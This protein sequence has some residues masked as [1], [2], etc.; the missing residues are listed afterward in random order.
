MKRVAILNHKGGSG[1]T[2]T[3]VNLGAALAEAGKRVLVLDFDPAAG[4]SMWLGAVSDDGRPGLAQA[5]GGSADLSELIRE[6]A[7]PGLEIIPSTLALSKAEKS[8]ASEIGGETVLKRK[9]SGLPSGR[10]D[11]LLVDCPPTLGLLTL[12]ALSAASHVLIPVEAHVMALS[13]VVSL[14]ETISI[15][16]ER[17]NPGLSV[18]GVLACR[19]DGRTLHA[20]EVLRLLQDKFGSLFYSTRIRE[21]VKLAES[22]SFAKPVTLY[23][24][25]SPGAED[26]RALAREFAEKIS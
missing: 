22:P 5:V 15:V 26:Y 6:T 13:G 1:K 25:S 4:A 21:N 23:A 10:W 3:T 2:T 19:V 24:P 20:R 9:S 7:V 8:L 18:C 11:Y 17:L 12:N 14:M 16:R